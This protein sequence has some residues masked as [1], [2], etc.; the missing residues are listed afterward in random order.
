MTFFSSKPFL[1]TLLILLFVS[2]CALPSRAQLASEPTFDLELVD[3][4]ADFQPEK[5][6]ADVISILYLTCNGSDPVI[7]RCQGNIHRLEVI[8]RNQQ[9]VSWIYRPP[10]IH[11]DNLAAGQREVEFRFRVRHDGYSPG[12]GT[13]AT[14]LLALG[15]A[16]FWYPRQNAS[17]PHQVILNLETP[18]D[19][20]VSTNGTLQR[21]LPNNTRR[22]RTWIV[23]KPAP[24]GITLKTP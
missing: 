2:A 12:G 6:I 14:N 20:E 1:R 10:Y 23:S 5:Y 3:I 21:D 13:I 22:L 18:A 9:N 15:P 7:L 16:V 19:Y 8:G 11:L 4:Y 17:D 24:E